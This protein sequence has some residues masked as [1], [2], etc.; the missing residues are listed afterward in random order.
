[1]KKSGGALI[2]AVLLVAGIAVAAYGYY[3]Y[4]AAQ[5]SIGNMVGKV[6]TGKSEAETRAVVMMI[7]GG[8]GAV[9]GAFL[10]L[11]GRRR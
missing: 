3:E 1:M 8:A 10:A 9:L 6:F 11:M 4:S 5:Q 2:G 7:A